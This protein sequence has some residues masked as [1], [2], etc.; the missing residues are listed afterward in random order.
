MYI[1]NLNL[2]LIIILLLLI[3]VGFNSEYFVNLYESFVNLKEDKEK[4][5]YIEIID[6]IKAFE[7]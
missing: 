6:A 7:Q 3:F 2:I 1:S 4:E 5:D